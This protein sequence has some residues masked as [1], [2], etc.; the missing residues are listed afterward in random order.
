M[1]AGLLS[2]FRSKQPLAPTKPRKMG[3]ASRG[4]EGVSSGLQY[5]ALPF[6]VGSFNEMMRG[7]RVKLVHASRNLTL[8]YDYL[9]R[10]IQLMYTH[11]I[12]E[13]GPILRANYKRT[14][15]TPHE[16]LNT[17]IEKK[18]REFSLRGVCEVTGT[19]SMLDFYRVALSKAITDGEVFIK[20]VWAKGANKYGFQLQ[21]IDSL[22]CDDALNIKRQGTEIR[23]G[24]EYDQNNRPIAYYFMCDDYRRPVDGFYH[25][26]KYYQRVEAK[27]VRHLFFKI[28]EPQD[29]GVPWSYAGMLRARHIKE[30]EN[31]EL[32]AS[33]IGSCKM[34]FYVRDKGASPT[35]KT[36]H[37]PNEDDSAFDKD[38]ETGE[39]VD[40]AAPGSFT[41]LPPGYNFM[42]FSPEHPTD[43]FEPFMK[44]QLRALASSLGVSV[45]TLVNDVENVNYS[46]LRS[47]VMEERS[48]YRVVQEWLV[49]SLCRPVF[50]QWLLSAI[51]S[52]QVKLDI[53]D[54]DEIDGASWQTKRWGWVD[55]W[56]ESRSVSESLKN[57][58]KSRTEIAKEQGRDIEDVF[59]ELFREKQMMEALGIDDDILEKKITEVGGGD[60]GED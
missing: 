9:K 60:E 12:G 3:R 59:N 25:N 7:S 40:F 10:Y 38:E 13:T 15:K 44:S 31:N 8:N 35:K 57:K 17:Q 42:P 1:I 50:N 32:I 18:W 2:L 24:I 51:L 36:I 33:R 19:M 4:F 43:L 54:I 48:F 5:P 58:T 53:E 47:N 20:Y 14:D 45:N 11:I 39:L 30:F 29:R 55:P 21:L 41:E 56:R 34:G 52:N 28:D 49:D 46:S 23:S 16:K 6:N 37:L 26:G 22:A 27:Q